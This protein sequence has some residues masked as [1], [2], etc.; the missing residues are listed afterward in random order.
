[1]IPSLRSDRDVRPRFE[2]YP[3]DSPNLRTVPVEKIPFTIGRGERTELQ[4][5]STSVSR[6]HAQLVKTPTGYRLRD[7]ES[8]NGTMINGQPITD[9]PLN[10]GD[11]VS[12][13]DVELTFLCASMGKLQRMVTQPLAGRKP[14]APTAGVPSALAATRAMSE[15]LLF[16]TPPLRWTRLVDRNQTRTLA[17][18]AGADGAADAWLRA[19]DMHQ[20]RSAAARLEWLTW[21]MA[22]AEADRHADGGGLLLRVAQREAIDDRLLEALELASG[23]LPGP[24]PVGVVAHWEW[25]TASPEVM[26]L[27]GALRQRGFLLAFDEF[28]GGGTCVESMEQAAPNYLIFADNVVRGAAAQPRRLQRIEIVQATCESAGIAPVMPASTAE[29]DLAACGQVGVQLKLQGAPTTSE[30]SQPAM[31]ALA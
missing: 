8:T 22:A 3:V 21:Q 19:A 30:A 13:A 9:A 15:T 7:L 4:I 26:R 17:T 28:S 20:P 2:F 18:L 31:A 24:R 25:A 11:S 5:H 10:D 1:V 14:P 12:I 23:W 29:D 27:C 6:E 16:Q